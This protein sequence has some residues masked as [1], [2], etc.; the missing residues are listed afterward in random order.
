MDKYL[1][2]DGIAKTERIVLSIKLERE[3]LEHEKKFQ[4]S[5]RDQVHTFTDNIEKL[6]ELNNTPRVFMAEN[7]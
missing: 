5:H 3:K 4:K 2:N 1:I 7:G 6:I